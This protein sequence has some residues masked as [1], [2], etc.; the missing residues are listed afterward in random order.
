MHLY[1]LTACLLIFEQKNKILNY[2]M[3]KAKKSFL[4]KKKFQVE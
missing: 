2:K 3:L 4:F 1:G